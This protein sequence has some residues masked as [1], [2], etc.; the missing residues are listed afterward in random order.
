ML[1]NSHSRRMNSEAEVVRRVSTASCFNVRRSRSARRFM[2][3]APPY[4]CGLY[5]AMVSLKYRELMTI[6]VGA[7]FGNLGCLF[8]LTSHVRTEIQV[9]QWKHVETYRLSIAAGNFNVSNANDHLVACLAWWHL[10]HLLVV[11]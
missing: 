10:C 9:L 3:A 4:F 11:G 8:Y 2:K 5:V 7:Q 6:D 1:S